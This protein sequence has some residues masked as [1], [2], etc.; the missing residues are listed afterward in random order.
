MEKEMLSKIKLVCSD[1]DG[2]LVEEGKAG[3]NPEY[4]DEIRRLKDKGIKVCAL[5]PGPVSTEFANVASNGAREKVKH[6]LP[7]DKV[8]K[9]CLKKATKGKTIV[10]YA[11]KWKF[12]AFGS[13][14][15]GKNLVAWYTYKFCKRPCKY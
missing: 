8:V 3:L 1:V 2:T 4:F 9:H 11:F 14:F 10:L 13:R 6:G 15:V 12:A 7:A 5:C